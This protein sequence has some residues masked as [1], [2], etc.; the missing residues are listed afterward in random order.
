MKL[1][2][3][4]KVR[5]VQDN[6]PFFKVG[7]VGVIIEVD[8]ENEMYD[9]DFSGEDAYEFVGLTEAGLQVAGEGMHL[10]MSNEEDGECW[11]TDEESVEAIEE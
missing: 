1:Q 3:G 10:K 5:A 6:S 7:A 9:I 4:Q 8:E 2:V 11:V